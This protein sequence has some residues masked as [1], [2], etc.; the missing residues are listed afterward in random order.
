MIINIVET[1]I[2]LVEDV[3]A[4]FIERAFLSCDNSP[5]FFSTNNGVEA[6]EYLRGTN[7]KEKV[8]KP[9]IILLDLDMSHMNGLQVLEEIRS[10]FSLKNSIVFIMTNTSEEK[11]QTLAYDQHIAG[12]IIKSSLEVSVSY[13]STFLT[14]TKVLFEF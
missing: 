3:D 11:F 5:K 12:H 2:L 13:L 9:F 10:D 8:N 6:L 4:S 7:N 14:I 1:T